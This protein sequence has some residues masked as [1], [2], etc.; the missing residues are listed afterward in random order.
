[1]IDEVAVWNG[2]KQLMEWLGAIEIHE[3]PARATHDHHWHVYIR[4]T[5]RLDVGDHRHYKKFDIE[6]ADGSV[7][8]PDIEQ[9]WQGATDRV[10]TL[11]Y[12]AKQQGGENRH[13]YGAMIEPIPSFAQMYRR[14]EEG[15]AHADANNTTAT[16]KLRSEKWGDALNRCV[17][18]A[19]CENMLRLDYS[20]VFYMH[21]HQIKKNLAPR[22]RPTFDHQHTLAEF[23]KTLRDF[24][25]AD[26]TAKPIVVTGPSNVGKT[27]W[28]AAHATNPLL[29]KNIEDARDFEPGFHDLLLFDDVNF[30][31]RSAEWAIALLDF[32]VDR[33]VDARYA[34]VRIPRKTPMIFTTN[35]PMNEVMTSIFPPGG[36]PQQQ[37]A[38]DRRFTIV[39]VATSLFNT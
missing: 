6:L 4:F 37:H 35:Y 13:L 11:A 39:R 12:V 17:T 16:V 9:V 3:N 15:D 22:F 25:V 26:W 27:T 7:A 20:N 36:N 30:R 29:I 31:V 19:E 14:N 38:I 24:N 21:W 33:T 32:H 23:T 5:S 18:L 10:R 34:P 1:M 28:V 8:H 2:R